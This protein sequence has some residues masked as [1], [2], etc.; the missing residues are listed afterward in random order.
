AA[1]LGCSLT[2]LALALEPPAADE[3]RPPLLKAAVV[4]VA[5]LVDD[6]MRLLAP[7]SEAFLDLLDPVRGVL[8]SPA[9]PE[10]RPALLDL[11]PDTLPRLLARELFFERFLPLFM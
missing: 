10:P 5:E 11:M 1:L 8:E 9:R 6:L 7:V 2:L 4:G 3:A